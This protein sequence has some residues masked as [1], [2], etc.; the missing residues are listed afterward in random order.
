MLTRVFAKLMISRWFPASRRMCENWYWGFKE[1]FKGGFQDFSEPIDVHTQR[2]WPI[3]ITHENFR[4]LFMTLKPFNNILLYKRKITL[5]STSK[6]GT[7]GH[8]IVLVYD[9]KILLNIS[10][11]RIIGLKKKKII[12]GAEN[13]LEVGTWNLSV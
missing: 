6:N 4:R 2:I 10:V 8:Y 7:V 12:S 1:S 9:P 5:K 13:L 3:R 11:S